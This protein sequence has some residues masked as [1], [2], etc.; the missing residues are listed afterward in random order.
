MSLP[1]HDDEHR[2]NDYPVTGWPVPIL[3][4]IDRRGARG[5]LADLAVAG[6]L[7]RQAAYIVAIDA[8]IDQPAPFLAR[9]GIRTTGAAGVGEALRTRQARDLIAA[10]YAVAPDA[11]PTGFLRALLRIEEFDS[12]K[13]GFD[14]F[15]HCQ[16]YRRL[17]DIFSTERHGR[18]AN[19]LR[20]CGPLRSSH[21]HAAEHLHPALVY[22]EIVATMDTAAHVVRVNALLDLIR[23]SVSMITEDEISR[24]LR[25]SLCGGGILERFARRVLE[26]AD[27]LPEPPL[28]LC[29]D[30]RP[31]RTAGEITDFGRRMGNC[32][33]TKIFEIVLGLL[34]VYEARHVLG[35]G[36]VVPLAISLTPLTSGVWL[37]GDVTM[38]RNRRP[39][40]HVLRAVLGRLQ[41][42]GAVVSGPSLT[43]PY[44]RDVAR[45]LGMRMWGSIDDCLRPEIDQEE[46][47]DAVE[48]LMAEIGEAA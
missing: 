18:K 37:V 44:R 48:A 39:P 38:R 24:T 21:V 32:A 16:S 10:T 29:D 4:E 3:A 33:G 47:L 17:F 45:L 14:A 34:Y 26:K 2:H 9:L 22:P 11:V 20:Y 36:S 23:A 5:L 40:A 42:L 7:A 19:A 43:A 12:D 15:I 30:L 8:D 41:D 25:E 31:L 1:E 35:D 28:P 6:A 46:E 13:P 27:C